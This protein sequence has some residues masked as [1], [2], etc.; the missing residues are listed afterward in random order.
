MSTWA[1]AI[2][3]IAVSDDLHI[4]PLRANGVTYGTPTW[5]WSVVVAD[6]L[7][8]RAWNG[9]RSRW[10]GSAMT[11]RVGRIIASGRPTR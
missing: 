8:V 9:K 5:I 3:R 1:Q 4:A 6:R 2:E 11:Q 7:Y 10:Y